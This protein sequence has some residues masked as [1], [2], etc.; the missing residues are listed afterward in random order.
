MKIE[1]PYD[2]SEYVAQALRHQVDWMRKDVR[3]APDAVAA[4]NRDADR[5][6][7]IADDI[8]E[9]RGQ[10]TARIAPESRA[11]VI[12]DVDAIRRMGKSI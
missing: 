9:M 4:L 7:Q 6:E 2:L 8:D 3:H 5:L 1:V 11:G 12:A 10:D